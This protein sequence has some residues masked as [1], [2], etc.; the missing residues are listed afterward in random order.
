MPE[1]KW[2]ARVAGCEAVAAQRAGCEAGRVCVAKP[3]GDAKL[4]VYRED[5][6]DCPAEMYTQRKVYYRD[7]DDSRSCSACT[8]DGPDCKY[9]WSVF[10]ATDTSCASPIIKLTS[11]G[12]CV[13]VNPSADKLRVG[14]TIE[15][16]GACTPG[17][18]ASSGGVSG[19]KPVTV[20]CEN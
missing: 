17:G 15:G 7:V 2:S 3:S 14:A 4:C 11:A 20:C 9:T 1:V 19:S 10:N 18:G 12:Q 13:Q 6:H 8:C 5:E 16:D